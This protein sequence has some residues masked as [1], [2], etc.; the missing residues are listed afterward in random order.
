MADAPDLLA[1]Y[2]WTTDE[3]LRMVDSGALADMPVELLEGVITEMT[4]QGDAHIDLIVEL[5]GLLAP[6]AAA[7][8]LAVQLPGPRTAD[9]MPEPDV[10]VVAGPRSREALL[11]IEVVVS[12][13][14]Q[15]RAKERIYAA[16]SVPEYWIVDVP[17]RVVEVL[18]S[19]GEDGYERRDTRRGADVLAVPEFGIAFT[20]DELFAGAGLARS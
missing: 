18:T 16:A 9:S 1:P 13:R 20:V 19:P 12:Q 15:A 3:Y 2:R 7:R 14:R 4:P 17:R 6:A 8:R 10:A 5:T 11:T